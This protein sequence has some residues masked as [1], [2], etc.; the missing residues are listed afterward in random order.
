VAE[1]TGP[2]KRIRITVD[3]DPADHRALSL[4]L[5]GELLDPHG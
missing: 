3:L 4:L 5:E 1:A 2:R